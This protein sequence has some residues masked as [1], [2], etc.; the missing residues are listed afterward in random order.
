[1]A[2]STAHGMILALSGP[3]KQSQPLKPIRFD[4]G[5][6]VYRFRVQCVPQGEFLTADGQP[7]I[8]T[9]PTL[10]HWAKTFK[11]F[12][13]RGIS[14]PV[15][16]GTHLEPTAEHSVG[17]VTGLNLANDGK[18]LWATMELVGKDAPRLA[19]TNSV[20]IFAEPEW[21]DA[22]GNKYKWP[23]RHVLI[24]PDAR[25]AGLEGPLAASNGKTYRIPILRFSNM[26]TTKPRLKPKWINY[27]GRRVL[28]LD[29][30]GPM[31]ENGLGVPGAGDGAMLPED[32]GST[33]GD[34]SADKGSLKDH[35]KE[36]FVGKAHTVLDDEQMEQEEKLDAIREL[37]AEMERILDA[38]E[39]EEGG[40]GEDGGEGGSAKPDE[41][42]GARGAAMANLKLPGAEDCA[43][44]NMAQLRSRIGPRDAQLAQLTSSNRRL[45]INNLWTSGK[46]SPIQK[47]QLE[48]QFLNPQHVT[49]SL[50]NAN[51]GNSFDQAISLLNANEEGL[52]G[53]HTGQQHNGNPALALGNAYTRTEQQVTAQEAEDKEMA[54]PSSQRA[55]VS[56]NGRH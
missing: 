3:R 31:N 42:E 37:L 21:T 49:L 30:Y 34:L 8:V 47:K 28:A 17:R 54:L 16:T 6:P 32:A 18:S 4:L 51:F 29:G 15:L 7:F 1:M 35:I 25:L 5:E 41:E 38:F 22:K 36:H 55:K 12:S 43:M 45:V 50:S 26:P 52:Y 33:M 44:S 56:K 24:T 53:E 27:K 48:D 19:A 11:A 39:E 10:E 23:V 20:S 14:V 46:I 9:K 40:V 13:N 2:T